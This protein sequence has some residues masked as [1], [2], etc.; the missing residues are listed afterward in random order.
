M[1]T[2]E[3]I[4]LKQMIKIY[5]PIDTDWMG[6]KIKKNNPLTFHHIV[7]RKYG[8][9]IV[10]NGALLTKKS[11]QLLN[12]LE[13]RNKDLFERWQWLFIEI[14]CSNTYPSSAYLEEIRELR[15][16]TKEFLYGKSKTLKFTK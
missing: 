15:R 11:H 13:S 1:N 12:K 3:Q 4:V 14:N 2:E 10:S 8:D 9:T 6:T 7:K 16:E 5:R